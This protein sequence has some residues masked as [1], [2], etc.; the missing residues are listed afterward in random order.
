METMKLRTQVDAEG[1]LHVAV[2]RHYAN[3]QGEVVVV[4]QT[5]SNTAYDALGYPLDFFA[6]LDAIEA[7]DVVK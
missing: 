2:P 7:D 6:R 3:Q 1:T 4:F 5:V